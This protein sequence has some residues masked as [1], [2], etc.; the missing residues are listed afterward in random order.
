MM[1]ASERKEALIKKLIELGA[2]KTPKIIEAFK[3]IDRKEFLPEYEKDLA[4]E[5]VALPLFK[6]ATISQPYTVAI[7]TEALAPKEGDKIL[8]IGTGSG[9]QAAILGYV[10]GPS[11]KVITVEIDRDLAEFARTNIKKVGLKNVKVVV[12]DGSLGYPG[13]APYDGIMVTAACPEIPMPLLQQLKIGG[14]LVAPVGSMYEQEMVV[15]EKIGEEKF[16]KKTL[17]AFVFVPL[18]GRYGFRV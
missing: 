13:E 17:G 1:R 2:L 7:M 12:G 5:D 6:G 4:Y 3:K 14:R 10:V 16:R 9:W 11:G 8:E 15:V 18:R